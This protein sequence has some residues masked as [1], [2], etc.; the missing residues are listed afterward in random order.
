M[1]RTT[2]TNGTGTGKGRKAISMAMPTRAKWDHYSTIAMGCGIPIASLVT[3]YFGGVCVAAGGWANIGC[4][5][6]F[7]AVCCAALAVSLPHLATAISELTHDSKVSASIL[8]VVLDAG[9]IIGEMTKALGC[10]DLGWALVAYM[11]AVTGW[12]MLLNCR[13]FLLHQKHA[14]KAKVA[15]QRKAKPVIAIANVG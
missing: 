12:S 15:T 4:G 13:A 10:V 11:T 7:L 8:A 1:G 9:I 3:S 2:N 5:I 6:A 14:A